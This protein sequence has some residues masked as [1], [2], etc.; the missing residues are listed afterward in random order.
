M[1][2]VVRCWRIGV[3][4]DVI[5]NIE[6]VVDINDLCHAILAAALWLS[7]YIGLVLIGWDYALHLHKV[8]V[9]GIWIIIVYLIVNITAWLIVV[10]F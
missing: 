9:F 6:L 4:N 10:I 7:T 2:R 5:R 8:I 1:A 3:D